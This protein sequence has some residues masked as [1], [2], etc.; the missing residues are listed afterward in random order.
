M[1]V[2]AIGWARVVSVLQKAYGQS[3]AVHFHMQLTRPKTVQDI[4]KLE[5]IT[6]PFKH[7]D[8]N[9][10]VDASTSSA[11][12]PPLGRMVNTYALMDLGRTRNY[13]T[14]TRRV[15]NTPQHTKTPTMPPRL[16]D[17]TPPL[18]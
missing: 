14:R 8:A 15:P 2:G 11:P 12:P 4:T 17:G 16:L 1:C 6:I 10:S 13:T 3:M 9:A 5:L 7:E 18:G